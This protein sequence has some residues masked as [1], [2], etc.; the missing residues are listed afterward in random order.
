MCRTVMSLRHCGKGKKSDAPPR[1]RKDT[2]NIA[3]EYGDTACIEHRSQAV[4]KRQAPSA[5]RAGTSV[6]MRISP[7]LVQII[8]PGL[9]R[10]L[11]NANRVISGSFKYSETRWRSAG[12]RLPATNLQFAIQA[13]QAHTVRATPNSI[14]SVAMVDPFYD[15][16][17]SGKI[18]AWANRCDQSYF[19]TGAARREM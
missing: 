5:L 12:I 13:L 7:V 16:R 3:H 17:I 11:S 4:R 10:R 8:A 18:G 9:A 2:L 6:R 15:G 1:Y 19:Q 14:L